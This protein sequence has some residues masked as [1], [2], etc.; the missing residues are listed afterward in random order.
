[1]TPARFREFIHEAP[2]HLQELKSL[3]DWSVD[4]LAGLEY[5]ADMNGI[6]RTSKPFSG[7]ILIGLFP[8]PIPEGMP[9]NETLIS[10]AVRFTITGI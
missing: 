7:V 4:F 6:V 3:S 10:G 8:K 5:D 9:L 1:M 2:G